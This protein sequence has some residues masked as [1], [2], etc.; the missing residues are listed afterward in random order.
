MANEVEIL[1]AIMGSNKTNGII[2]WMDNHPN[3]KYIYISPLLSEVDYGSRLDTDVKNIKFEFPS[4]DDEY[5][6]KGEQLLNM[7]QNGC[8]IGATHS[9]YLSMTDRHLDVIEQ[10]G[11]VILADEEVNA[12][13]KFDKYSYDD[14]DYLLLKK[15]IKISEVDGMLSWVG[16]DLG[17]RNKYRH[18]ADMCDNKMIYS[19]K[20]DKAMMVTQLPIRLFTCAKRVIIMTY[21][22]D[23]NIL[24]CFLRLKGI[25]VKKFTEVKPTPISKKDIRSLITLLP[26]DDKVSKL[27]QTNTGYGKMTQAQLDEIGKYITRVARRYDIDSKDVLFTLPKN[28]FE[29]SKKSHKRIRPKGYSFYKE[30]VFDKDG[31][32]VYDKNSKHKTVEKPC[33]LY[34][35]CRATNEYSNTWLLFHCYD[36]HP[37]TAVASYLADYGYAP[38][39]NVFRC[40][41][42]TQWV[43]R[44]RIRKSLPIVL[45]ITNEK[46]YNVFTNWLNNDEI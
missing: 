31:N 5:K 41:E 43:F 15:D 21:M 35:G 25:K 11:Y 26:L 10:Q 14:L 3:E 27:N 9:L 33:W 32:A 19:A 38:K 34:A 24:D 6:T 18:F 16:V 12:I 28:I 2:K 20:R 36:R 4:V 37:N 30:Y 45:A 29:P 23:G 42:I 44:S 13:T 7:L 46:M 40:S 22:F 8:N 17:Q 39:L 1:D